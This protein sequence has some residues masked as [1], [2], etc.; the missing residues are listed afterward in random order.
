[1]LLGSPLSAGRLSGQPSCCLSLL[2]MGR[3]QAGV[4]S[5]PRAGLECVR[6]WTWAEWA[7]RQP[8][9]QC[10]PKLGTGSA[11]AGCTAKGSPQSPTF[12]TVHRRWRTCCSPNSSP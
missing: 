10:I 5:V 12:L 7:Q 2:E 9:P 6:H 8:T 3:G 4:G 11:G 1:M